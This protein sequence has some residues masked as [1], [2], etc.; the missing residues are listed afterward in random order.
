MNWFLVAL[1]P[2]LL[3]AVTNLIDKT[4]LSKYFQEGG[5]G[6]LLMFSALLSVIAI[7]LLYLVEPDVMVVGDKNLR[8]IAILALLDIVL[9]WSYLMALKDAESSATIFYYQLVPVMALVMGYFH[10]NETITKTQL[11]AMAIII[12]G[13]SL[14][15]FEKGEDGLK[16]KWK[17]VVFMLIACVCWASESV[18]FKGVALEE[19]IWRSLFW[20]HVMLLI[21]GVIMFV[22]MPKQRK[23]FLARFSAKKTNIATINDSIIL[24]QQQTF[25]SRIKEGPSGIIAL[26]ILNESL[27]MSGNVVA[28]YAFMLAPVAL[29]LLAETFQAFFVLVLGV[30]LTFVLPKIFNERTEKGTVAKKLFAL[31]VTGMGTYILLSQ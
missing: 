11:L 16:F 6:T 26:N 25:I 12:F 28:A 1:V 18:F 27:Y 22:F 30:T 31:T 17:T 7:P 14:V 10:L 23:N 21:I 20:K 9:V 5:V 15:S 24:K 29:A 19:N 3:Y 13:T 2:P 4:L 8:T